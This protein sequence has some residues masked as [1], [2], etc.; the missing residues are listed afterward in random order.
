M[1]S[2]RGDS[3]GTLPGD[4]PPLPGDRDTSVPSWPA[5][6]RNLGGQTK[7]TRSLLAKLVLAEVDVLGVFPT[8]KFSQLRGPQ[9]NDR[10]HACVRLRRG[11]AASP[12]PLWLGR[13]SSSWPKPLILR[14][15]RGMVGLKL[16]GANHLARKEFKK[17]PRKK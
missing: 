4:L 9:K 14:K 15:W 6:T 7:K 10:A 11:R 17:D 12:G 3:F 5:E 1:P 13:F 2:G 16:H 8:Q